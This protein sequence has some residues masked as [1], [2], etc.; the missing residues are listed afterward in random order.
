MAPIARPRFLDAFRS[1]SYRLLWSGAFVSSVGTWTQDVA[2][3]WII[4]TT[5]RDPTY[6]GLRAFAAEAPLLAFMLVGGAFADRFD[7]RAILLTSQ[8]L[9]M[10]FAAVL[11]ALFIT[12][13]LG[14][15]PILV[16]AFL[17]GLTQS[18]SAPTYQ[19]V[20]TTVVSRAQI[21][22]AVALNSLQFNLSRTVGPVVAGVLLT[23]AGPGTCFFTNAVSFAAV[24]VA[25]TK[26]EVP[27]PEH[28]AVAESL[29]AS[30]RTGLDHV[31]SNPLL[32]A[33]VAL[34]GATSFLAFPLLTYLPVLAGTV[35][36]TGATGF[37]LLLASFGAGAILGAIATA[38]RGQVQ[39]RGR[40]LLGGLLLYGIAAAV[41]VLSARQSVAMVLL[42]GAGASLVTGT[43]TLNSLVQE[44]A[45]PELKGRILAI[46][47]LAFRGGMPLGSLL[48]GPL[49][50][51]FGAPIVLAAFS[52][53]L[54]VTA[55][56]LRL[57]G[58]RL[59][60]L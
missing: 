43:S 15:V 1:R 26:I 7:K 19:A 10:S 54:A 49:V 9:Q 20:L 31:R 3:A 39:G 35:L 12:G 24:I 13:R 60:T 38:Q 5:L 17:T 57:R 37:S 40:I 47:G 14:I 6:L 4:H 22:S 36:R 41:A 25:L 48:A 18:Q 50:G 51:H 33:F 52:L 27:P 56:V 32:A 58:G 45:P 55:G 21:P 44:I 30:L 8:V 42:F 28:P 23:Y 53:A 11:G 29:G 34:G 16:L 46:Y 2:L 59:A